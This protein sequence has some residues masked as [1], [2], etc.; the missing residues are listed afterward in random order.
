M[1]TIILFDFD[2]DD[3]ELMVNPSEP[4]RNSR[5]DSFRLKSTRN[6]TMNLHL[7]GKR[8]FVSGSSSG[9]GA[10]IARKLVQEG[11]IVVVHG[12][13]EE[14]AHQVG[15]EIGQSSG[16]VFVALGD[17]STD[18]GAVSATKQAL[19]LLGDLD[20][21]VNNAGARTSGQRS[22]GARL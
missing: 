4:V 3:F 16:H 9:I 20:I 18:E 22:N 17:L 19:Q 12:R 11:A 8:A 7:E 5:R 1:V 15:N 13:S 14:K 21:L 10:A 2:Y 6:F